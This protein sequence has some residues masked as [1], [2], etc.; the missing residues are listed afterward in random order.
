MESSLKY[1]ILSFSPPSPPPLFPHTNLSVSP[2][3]NTQ[4]H[5]SIL[6]PPTLFPSSP[7][8]LRKATDHPLT[9]VLDLDETLVHCSITEI[10][11]STHVFTVDS[12]DAHYTVYVRERPHLREFLE[13]ISHMF[14]VV[15]FTASHR[16]YADRLAG[17]I[18]PA[19]LLL[20]HRLFRE[21]CVYFGGN[22]IKVR[23]F[24]S[25]EGLDIYIYIY[26]LRSAPLHKMLAL[27]KNSTHHSH[28][29]PL[30][31]SLCTCIFPSISFPWSL[32]SICSRAAS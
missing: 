22:Y 10:P 29:T 3:P 13:A 7:A 19:R 4:T 17:I 5:T 1:L 8:L 27:I 16:Q 20:P 25:K 14:E 12:D 15:L 9:L 6:P 24:P 30:F 11:K 28:C 2:I 31:V 26:F 18:D 32:E 21:H 23:T